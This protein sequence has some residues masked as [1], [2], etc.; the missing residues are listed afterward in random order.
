MIRLEQITKTFQSGRKT[1]TAVDNVS[2]SVNDGEI[3]GVIG[4]SGAG[5]STLVRCINLLER[6]TSGKV[7]L[8]DVELTALPA[9]EIRRRRQEIGMI[10]QQFNLFAARTVFDNVA[11]PLRRQK[12]SR[13][14]Q[15]QR[16]TELLKLVGLEQKAGA[17]PSELSGGQKQRVAIARALAS[18]P[19]VLLCDEA[20][21]ALDPQTTRATLR[22]LKDLNRKLGLTIILITHEMQVVKEICDRVAVMENG[23]VVEEGDVF[24]VFSNPRQPVTR[25]FISMTSNL[26]RV[27]E[28][29][30]QDAAITRLKPGQ[31]ILRMNYIERS[32][33]EALVSQLSRQFQVDLNII[34]GN[35]EMIGD[36]PIGGL[37]VIVSGAPE[38]IEKTLGYL[39]DIH[40]GVE[41]ISDA[42][43]SD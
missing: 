18:G 28:L 40:V 35:I 21:S 38:S 19:K 6:P 29:L 41:V 20:T 37:V 13:A 30:E 8:D 26:S 16:V 7:W 25:N 23:R 42:R 12:L 43:V 2:L 1:V 36:N 33:C 22:L 14:A 15:K 34:F 17:Y 10:F 4:F 11:F 9:A 5:K 32:A 24:T 3:F 27:Y 39:K 31:L